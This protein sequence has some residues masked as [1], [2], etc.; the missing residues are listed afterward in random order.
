MP[1]RALEMS[2]ETDSCPCPFLN[3]LGGSGKALTFRSKG[4]A[5]LHVIR[6]PSNSHLLCG[7]TSNPGT[8]ALSSDPVVK[9]EHV[10]TPTSWPLL[11]AQPP[12]PL[13]SDG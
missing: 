1:D 4:E 5:E 7:E 13:C 6:V 9:D 12:G 3:Q 8:S 2:L 10:P 11:P